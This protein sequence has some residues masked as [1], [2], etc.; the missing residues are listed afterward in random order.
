MCV[1]VCVLGFCIRSVFFVF[2][3]LFFFF[4]FCLFVGRLV[5]PVLLRILLSFARVSAGSRKTTGSAR[6]PRLLGPLQIMALSRALSRLWPSPDYAATSFRVYTARDYAATSFR[7]FTLYEFYGLFCASFRGFSTIR[8]LWFIL[9]SGVL[10]LYEF[11]GLFC[12][13]FRDFSSIRVLWFILCQF[14]GF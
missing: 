5:F 13:S 12:A 4:V 6:T 2:F 9:F 10:V 3:V 11:Y 1:C 7:V 14:Q 8:V